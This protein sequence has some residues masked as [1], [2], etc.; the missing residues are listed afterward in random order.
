MEEGFTKFP[1][2]LPESIHED[3]PNDIGDFFT[4]VKK[5]KKFDGFKV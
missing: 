5:R 1:S 2:K 4:P 3:S